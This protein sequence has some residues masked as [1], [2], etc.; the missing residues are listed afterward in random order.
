MDLKNIDCRDELNKCIDEVFT[1]YA[2]MLHIMVDDQSTYKKAAILY[3][4]MRDFKNYIRREAT[5]DSNLCPSF[6][7]GSL[8]NVNL[9][10]NVG[11]ELGGLHY[12]VVLMDSPRKNP[13]LVVV[14]LTSVKPGKQIDK[15]RPTELFMGDELFN[16]VQG[17]YAAL[18]TSI[19]TEIKMLTDLTK[20]NT[21][22]EPNEYAKK[23]LALKQHV[24]LLQKTMKKM[25]VLKHGSIA[26][27]NQI[28]S[29]SKMRIQ[30]PCDKYDILYGLK[31]SSNTLDQIDKKIQ[32]L[33]VHSN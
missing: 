15:L 1:D 19:P 18:R 23:I 31:L 7:R 5:F 33:F 9:G 17:K 3:Y 26:V 14:P 6:E 20:H 28:R 13:N 11:S 32:E 22:I 12:A 21:T 4:W 30:D 16:K 10:F 24:T 25:Q 2:K 8:V 29:I 27:M